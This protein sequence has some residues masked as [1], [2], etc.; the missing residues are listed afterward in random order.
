M[1]DLLE[2]SHVVEH[3]QWK[4]NAAGTSFFSILQK[5]LD[6]KRAISRSIV[7]LLIQPGNPLDK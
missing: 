2:D 4:R 5:L 3:G 1:M 6:N 7:L